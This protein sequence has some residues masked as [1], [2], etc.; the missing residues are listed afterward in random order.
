MKVLDTTKTSGITYL[1]YWLG[2]F[3]WWLAHKSLAMQKLFTDQK[4]HCSQLVAGKW[5]IGTFTQELTLAVMLTLRLAS[6]FADVLCKY[7]TT[8]RHVLCVVSCQLFKVHLH[9]SVPY[10]YDF[11]QY[12]MLHI[13]QLI[14]NFSREWYNMADIGFLTALLPM[15][16]V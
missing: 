12:N 14:C 6:P 3:L 8:Y 4:H 9:C 1:V 15:L 7:R 13:R 11:T 10:V 16:I 2:W 5:N